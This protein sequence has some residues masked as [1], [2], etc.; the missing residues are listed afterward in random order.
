M[1]NSD[2]TFLTNEQK[3]EILAMFYGPYKNHWRDKN[4]VVDN[5]D[6]TIAKRMN[7]KTATVAQFLISNLTKK[8]NDFNDYVNNKNKS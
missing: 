2:K 4:G 7:V 6:S 3:E 1:K 5:S 8:V